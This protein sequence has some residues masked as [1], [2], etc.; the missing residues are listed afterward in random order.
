MRTFS[1]R[2]VPVALCA[3]CVV[4]HLGAHIGFV[5]KRSKV[6]CRE[7]GQTPL[8]SYSVLAVPLSRSAIRRQEVDRREAGARIKVADCPCFAPGSE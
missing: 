1:T 7:A 2:G 6:R 5:R 3:G 4:A 8:L